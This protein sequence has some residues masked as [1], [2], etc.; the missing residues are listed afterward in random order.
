[1]KRMGSTMLKHYYSNTPS[2]MVREFDIMQEEDFRIQKDMFIRIEDM[3]LL[4]VDARTIKKILEKAGT[5]E[6][7]G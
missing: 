1:M 6:T 7:L 5:D 3:K 4:N 2:D